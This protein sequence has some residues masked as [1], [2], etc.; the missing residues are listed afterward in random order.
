MGTFLRDVGNAP[1]L[2]Q[3]LEV[4]EQRLQQQLQEQADLQLQL[5][6]HLEQAGAQMRVIITIINH[7]KS[8][9]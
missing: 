5:Q 4:Q 6:Q 2:R 7:P 8:Q 1:R 9:H 3:H